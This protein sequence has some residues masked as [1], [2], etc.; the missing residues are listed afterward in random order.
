MADVLLSGD[1]RHKLE[2]L[3][4]L[5]YQKHRPGFSSPAADKFVEINAARGLSAIIGTTV[6]DQVMFADSEMA[7]VYSSNI[8][9]EDI[10]DVQLNIIGTAQTDRNSCARVERVGVIPAEA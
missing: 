2:I 10:I 4:N 9:A 8:V 5:L 3:E 6:P 1:N 7:R